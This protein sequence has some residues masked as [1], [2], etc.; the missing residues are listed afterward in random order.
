MRFV[1]LL[2]AVFCSFMLSACVVGSVVGT[3]VGVAGSVV[4]T[5]V[6]V[7]GAVV[8]GAVGAVTGD[9]SDD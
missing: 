2:L 4:S 7:T 5:T 1:L 3:T 6:G 9:D 8:G